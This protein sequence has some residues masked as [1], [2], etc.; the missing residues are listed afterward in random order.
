MLYCCSKKQHLPRFKK[1]FFLW[2]MWP[3]RKCW[4]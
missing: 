4:Y 1:V 3:W 2:K